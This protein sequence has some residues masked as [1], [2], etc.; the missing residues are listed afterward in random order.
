MS[1]L[2]PPSW[3]KILIIRF[4]SI[5]DIVLTT[6]V[7]RCL[8]KKWPHLE[9]HYLTKRRNAEL[10]KSIPYIDTVHTFD[11]DLSQTIKML[12]KEDFDFVVDLQ[13]NFRSKKIIRSLKCKHSTFS[14]LNVKKWVLVR[15]KINL[16]PPIHIV[17][18]YFTAVQKLGVH[19][20]HKG[21]DFFIPEDSVFDVQDL[22]AGFEDGYI[23]VAIGAQHYTKSI[24]KE[25][26][27]EIGNMLFKPMVLLGDEN[28]SKKGDEIVSALNA[29]AFNACG[30]YSL[31]T[32]A[33]I[34]AQ[35]DCVL[36]SD[37]G[38][39]HI[40][41]ALHKPIASL[42][43]NTVPEFGMYPYIVSDAPPAR[44]FEVPSLVCRPCSKLG[45]KKC[46]RKHFQCMRRLSSY[47]IATWINQY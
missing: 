27:I 15:F 4:S 10:L 44:I 29:K 17:D 28:D 38:L 43:G 9:I 20:D 35:S 7:V 5:G 36:T 6:P 13:K 25:M 46:P 26:I 30:K 2:Q 42:W 31:F 18:R 14:K 33:S 3:R 37:T 34:I 41:A 11:D 16:L 21:L 8:K 40:A 24:P 47:E 1:D 23:A 39:M 12:K 22:P 45:Y 19:N 32:S